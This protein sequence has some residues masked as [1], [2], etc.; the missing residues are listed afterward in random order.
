MENRSKTMLSIDTHVHMLKIKKYPYKWPRPEEEKEIYADFLPEN[1]DQERKQTT[2]AYAVLVEAFESVEETEWFL[3]MEQNN[4]FIKGVVGFIDFT[5]KTFE[6]ELLRLKNIGKLV[7]LR[8]I[9]DFSDRA[10]LC[11]DDVIESM[12]T[13]AK[14]RLTFDLL[15]KSESQ[16]EDAKQFLKLIP[17]TLKVVIDHLGKPD[18]KHGASQQWFDDV[19]EFASYKNVY[20]KLSGMVTEADLENWKENDFTKYV[21]H[22]VKC[23]GVD[24]L[25][26]GSDWPVCKLAHANLPCVHRLLVNLLNDMSDE[27]KHKIFYSNAVKFYNL[28]I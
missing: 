23:F 17:N 24:R 28:Q 14:H 15:I 9:L 22:V 16:Y 26:F 19:A 1:Y 10:W 2:I 7:G 20:C 12:R 5:D 6:E 11:R 8:K 25:M 27:E 18:V 13:L 21:S 4:T 3:E